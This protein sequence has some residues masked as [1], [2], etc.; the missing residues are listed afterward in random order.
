MYAEAGRDT[1]NLVMRGS[2][3]NAALERSMSIDN[4]NTLVLDSERIIPEELILVSGT[5]SF[6][7]GSTVSKNREYRLR[8]NPVVDG[9][10]TLM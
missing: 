1:Q 7:S 6:A 8:I 9:L 4:L 3:T 5:Q 10:L 2:D